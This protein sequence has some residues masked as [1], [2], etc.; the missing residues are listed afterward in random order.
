MNYRNMANKILAFV[1]CLFL[2]SIWLRYV[3]RDVLFIEMF[4]TVMEAAFVGGVADWFAI[5]A[6]FKKPLGFPWHTE[7]IP[8]H[9]DRVI[10]SI[11]DMIE[12]DLLSIKSIKQQVDKVCFVKLMIDWI[13][14][15]GGRQLLRNLLDKHSKG[16]IMN[17]DPRVL[18]GYLETFIK[19]RIR[20]M[21]IIPQF[22]IVTKWGLEQEKDKYLI[23]FILNELTNRIQRPDTKKTIYQYMEDIKQ[24]KSKSLLEKTVIW[25]GEQTN[26]VNVSDAT[27]VLYQE[28]L[29]NLQEMKNPE[30]ILHEWIHARLIEIVNRPDNEI[31]WADEMEHWKETVAER[32]ELTEVAIFLT[33]NFI[34]KISTS[35]HAHL[36]ELLYSQAEQ[37]WERF[38]SDPEMQHWL[39]IRIKKAIFE[40][41][42]KE[43]YLIGTVVEEV[44]STFSD[45]DFNRFI[46]DKAG[47][48][49]QW[50]RINGC[51]VGAIV[52]F[53][54]FIFLHYFYD[55]NVV[56]IVQSWLYGR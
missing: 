16:L 6:I 14:H 5:T 54:M 30:H 29:N 23:I 15:S 2:L 18:A 22:K 13:E 40:L 4:Y 36:L 20:E 10:L 25:I 26:S 47:D 43:H 24:A 50:I 44:L 41:V 39:E 55:Q 27:D 34:E 45:E 7:L 52:G 1:F 3:Y 37:H 21:K 42:E 51:V 11:G 53:I 56:P 17:I 38:K 33:E 49:L 8:R 12:Q 48:D 9:R 31:P 46:E 19:T 35:T 32:I 28:L